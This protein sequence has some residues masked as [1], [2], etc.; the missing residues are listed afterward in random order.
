V[1]APAAPFADA[2]LIRREVREGGPA[3]LDALAAELQR[4][5]IPCACLVMELR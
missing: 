5:P 3:L 2:A 4:A 1:L